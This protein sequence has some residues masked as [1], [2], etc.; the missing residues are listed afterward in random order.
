M[1]SEEAV[2]VAAPRRHAQQ[3]SVYT[4]LVMLASV[5]VQ[6]DDENENCNKC[7]QRRL[8]LPIRATCYGLNKR[9]GL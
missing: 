4:C 9:I 6:V 7:Y 3:R 5:C 1:A 2:Q 8:R